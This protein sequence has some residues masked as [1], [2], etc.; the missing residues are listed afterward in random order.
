MTELL[1]F[2][3][4][5]DTSYS[6]A[7]PNIFAR[8]SRRSAREEPAP[9]LT[10]QRTVATDDIRRWDELFFAF[11]QIIARAQELPE[12]EI[13]EV[14]DLRPLSSQRIIVKIRE[15]KPAQFYYVTDMDDDGEEE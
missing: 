4:Y 14:F 1:P 3:K 6:E 15:I 11:Q 10:T 8:E 5:G 13:P 2:T 12:P 9:Y 7:I